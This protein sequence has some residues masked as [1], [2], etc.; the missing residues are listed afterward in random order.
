MLT[1][2]QKLL[3]SFLIERIEQDGVSPS[4]EEICLETEF[5]I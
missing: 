3:L 5:K 2:K 4:Y 1:K